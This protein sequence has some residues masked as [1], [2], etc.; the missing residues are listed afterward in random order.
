LDN[1]SYPGWDVSTNSDLDIFQVRRATSG[2]N[3]RNLTTL[4]T[5]RVNG[6]TEN[7]AEIQNYPLP[8]YVTTPS[9]SG[10][11]GRFYSRESSFFASG[12]T[13]NMNW[14]ADWLL[15]DQSKSGWDV[16]TNSD[17]DI[18]QIRRAAPGPDPVTPVKIF[19]VEATA[20]ANNATNLFV[21]HNDGSTT[22]LKRVNVGAADSAGTGFRALR[23]DN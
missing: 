5:I 22:T 3:P 15:D 13:N 9:P 6:T 10:S 18:F 7:I 17:L 23:V 16:S 12:F 21:L 11:I 1:E 19:Q 2:T 20:Y 8:R 14:S 4:F